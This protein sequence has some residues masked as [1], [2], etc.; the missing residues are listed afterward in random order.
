MA[1]AAQS[2]HSCPPNSSQLSLC[3]QWAGAATQNGNPLGGNKIITTA[4]RLYKAVCK[5]FALKSP[6]FQRY[7]SVKVSQPLSWL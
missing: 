3:S 7:L 4:L 1:T 6:G 5:G 2:T